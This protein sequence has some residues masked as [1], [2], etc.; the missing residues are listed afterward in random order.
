MIAR[1]VDYALARRGIVLAL[2][3]VVVLLGVRSFRRLPIEA[4]PDVAD[5]WVQ[6]ITQW[7]GHAAEEVERQLTIPTERVM[8]GVPR[9]TVVRS[10]SVAGLSV[11]TL[12]FE[13]GTD[14]YFARQQVSERLDKIELPHGVTST[15][16]P[17]ASPVGEILRYRIV[18]CAKTHVAVCKDE[19]IAQAPRPLHELKDIEEYLVERELLSV[20]GVAD[21][22]SFGGTTKQYQVLVDPVLL[23]AHSLTFDD[24][25]KALADANGNAGG[26]AIDFGRAALNVRGIGMLSADQIGDVMVSTKEGVPIRVRQ[27][28]RVQV[29]HRVR[30]G[31]VSVD[32]ERDVVAA[33]VLLRKGEQAE[34]VLAAVRGKI[35]DINER[36]LPRGVKIAPYHDRSEL[37]QST[38]LTVLKNLGEGM[39]LI[40]VV[41]FLFVGNLRAALIAAAVIPLSL[42]FAFVCMDQA[43]VPANLL[44]IGALD[45]G[46]VVDGAIVM[47]ENTFRLVAARQERGERF[48]LRQVAREASREVARPVVFAMATVVTAYLPIFTLERVEG[49]LFRPMAWTVAFALIGALIASITVVP[50]LASW[51][52]ARRLHEREN[53]V[54]HWTWLAY[55]RVLVP[56]LARPKRLLLLVAV[57]GIGDVMLIRHVGTEFLPHLDEGAVW[58][59]ATMPATISLSEAEALVDGVHTPE[60][61]LTGI[62]EILERYPEVRTMS[63]QIGRP[64]DGTD[65][66]GFYNAEVLLVL[67]DRRE[68]R[69]NFHGSK[70]LLIEAINQDVSA[71]PGVSFG[72]SQPIADNVEEALTGV[73][74]QLAVKITGDDLNA[75]D[76]IA[77]RIATSIHGVPGVVDLTVIRELGQ[78]NVNVDI[79]RDRAERFGLSVAAVEDVV[80]NGVGGQVVTSIV[81]GERRHDL[82][83]R[84]AEDLRK[85]TDALR[86]LLVPLPEGRLVPLAHVADVSVVGGASRIFRENGRRYIAVRFG[87]RA[88]DLG[89]TVD[90]AQAN[91]A[92]DVRLPPGYDIQWGG[93]FESARRAGRRLAIIVPVTLFAIFGLLLAAFRNLRDALVVVLNVLLTSPC[94]GLAALV[95]TGTNFSVSAGVGFLALFGVSVQTGVILV[96]RV[97]DLR[98]AGVSVDEALLEAVR[99]RLRPIVMTA[100]VATGG[101]L[102]AAIST[103]IGSDSQKPL[104]IVVVGGLFSSLA[105]S[106][107]VLPM[108]Y[109]LLE[110]PRRDV[111]SRIETEVAS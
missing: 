7:P 41:L 35:D 55:H 5:T 23:A 75:L 92:R 28:A 52:F 62:R 53:R 18:D 67:R 16:G 15:L 82:L 84:Y 72:F 36:M 78:S 85:D 110:R 14:S 74:G 81:D 9:K 39:L 107:V 26:G 1:I 68:W 46:M 45:F 56:A 44:S 100:L 108:L 8:N 38:T 87:V 73:K 17:L 19:D 106:L 11:V 98:A 109:K 105:L 25:A 101:L 33:T 104:A 13:D 43:S 60:R 102:P 27:V 97:N 47:V 86:E 103:G 63:V 6:I 2:V 88:R 50:V 79:S 61:E 40:G 54:L 22:V 91:V 58:M 95:A 21:V 99:K 20:N 48:D 66:T 64:D 42:L 4:Y 24:V 96:T 89:S 32:G 30:L 31:R 59:R 71:I 29:G 34:P 12:V 83:V 70:D 76:D 94:G 49:K 77:D 51:L 3:A 93:E 90:E 37:I 111:P 57:L 65:P 80:E 69:P 10:T